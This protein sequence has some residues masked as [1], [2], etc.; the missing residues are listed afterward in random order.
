MAIDA[1]TKASPFIT[2]RSA[3]P[4]EKISTKEI[5]ASTAPAPIDGWPSDS[6]PNRVSL[7]VHV[8]PVKPIAR[9]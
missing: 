3:R 8:Q 7:I 1:T 2:P 6:A 4:K 9:P 5:E